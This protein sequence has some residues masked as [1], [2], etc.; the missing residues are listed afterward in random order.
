MLN[1]K[2]QNTCTVNYIGAA[3][4][5]TC[6]HTAN[7]DHPFPFST[8]QTVHRTHTPPTHS[9]S[10]CNVAAPREIGACDLC[11]SFS[12]AVLHLSR[13]PFHCDALESKMFAM[14][15]KQAIF[16][17][18]GAPPEC[19]PNPNINKCDCVHIR[20]FRSAKFRI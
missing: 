2:M 7:R 1:P 4:T 11:A 3:A 13:V 8:I 12:S 15:S 16:L 20:Y 19:S 9:F 18:H 6:T 10:K 17:L 5:A 14:K